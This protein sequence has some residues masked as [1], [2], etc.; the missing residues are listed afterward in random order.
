[1][2]AHLVRLKLALL[3]N[4]LRRSPWQVVGM[5]F[6]LLYGLG[7]AAL[8]VSAMVAVS[9]QDVAL[10]RTVTVMLG[11]L[12]V[13]GWWFVPLLAFGV[14]AT[15]DPE[16]F[17]TFA[18][19]RRSLV[20]GLSI[21]AL[22]G[23]M[24][25]LTTIVALST[26]LAWWKHPLAMLVGLV[27]AVLG[28]GVAVVGGRAVV[29]AAAPLVARRRARE[30]TAAL[31]VLAVASIG[32]V[33]SGITSVRLDR[34]T[35]AGVVDV[36]VWTPFGAPWG[37]PADVAQGRPL[38]ALARLAIAAATLA[39]ALVV[40]DRAISRSLVSPPRREAAGARAGLGPFSRLPATPLG[41]VTA[42][43]LVYWVRDPRYAMAVAIVPIIP[44][45]LWVVGR[46][47]GILLFAGPFAAFVCG[48]GVSSDVSY[49]GSAFWTHVSAG[50]RGRVDRLGRVLASATLSAPIVLLI[51]VVTAALTGHARDLPALLGATL[52]VLGAA[53][54]GASI[55]SALVVQPV[56]QP[57]EN[58]FA[59]RQ[60]ASMSAMLSQMVG[61]FAVMA[62]TLPVVVP[63]WVAVATSSALLGW[64]AL[65]VGAVVCGACVV[66]GVRVGGRL[67]DQRA[68]VLLQRVIAF[69]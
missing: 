68:P 9:L 1:M 59:T 65:A 69:A 46:G 6:G 10:Q 12:L 14:D 24:G 28:L 21:A 56:Q 53:Y 54:G 15:L 32:P 30:L 61:S 38:L 11:S 23:V 27:G 43:C 40:W 44:V 8:V 20:V 41:A 3:R 57:G 42:R 60:G 66:V 19:P 58:P 2:V 45:L 55:L 37:A 29:A 36:L 62:A 47:E 22:L 39:L 64:I 18:I 17:A 63:A 50:V 31:A 5:V 33:L 13:A 7:I 52:G 26:G 51:T 67:L 48:W 4:G 34:D 25:V 16:R 49:D 35:F